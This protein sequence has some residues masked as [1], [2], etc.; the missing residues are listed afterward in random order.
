MKTVSL[1]SISAKGQAVY[2]LV[3]HGLANKSTLLI[4]EDGERVVEKGERI[5]YAY[6]ILEGQT[7]VWHETKEGKNYAWLTLP[8]KTLMSDMEIFSQKDIYAATTVS[9]GRSTLLKIPV[10]DL[11]AEFR[12]NYDFLMEVVCALANNAV[13]TTDIIEK[14]IYKTNIE[15]ITQ[16]ILKNCSK[17]TEWPY[18]LPMTRRA[19]A[20]NLGISA[21]TVDRN[22]YEL[23]SKN[24]IGLSKGKISVDKQQHKLLQNFRHI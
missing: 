7:V 19:I 11:K 6:Y 18:I 2:R 13:V 1:S 5:K 12:R 14:S 9:V 20:E 10:E 22:I 23:E 4:A 8:T 21:K 24:L 15:K 16:F 3:P 17:A